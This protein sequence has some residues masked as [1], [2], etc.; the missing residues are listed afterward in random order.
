MPK[1]YVQ[2]LRMRSLRLCCRPWTRRARDVTKIGSR[3]APTLARAARAVVRQLSGSM[4]R[5]ILW[6]GFRFVFRSLFFASAPRAVSRRAQGRISSSWGCAFM[7]VLHVPLRTA[8][9]ASDG[10]PGSR[11]GA[12]R[13]VGLG[14]ERTGGV[15][16]HPAPAPVGSRHKHTVTKKTKNGTLISEKFK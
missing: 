1:T 10:G 2:I 16:P 3:A 4:I 11:R 15:P 9:I 7:L 12:A 14:R 5:H 8:V 6:I 13:R